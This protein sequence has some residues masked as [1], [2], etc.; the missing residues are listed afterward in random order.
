[1]VI[2]FHVLP[3]HYMA[4]Q[5]SITARTKQLLKFQEV[6]V[7]KAFSWLYSLIKQLVFIEL[8]TKARTGRNV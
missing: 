6:Q 2:F 4:E 3:S 5:F 8:E 1:M 7:L